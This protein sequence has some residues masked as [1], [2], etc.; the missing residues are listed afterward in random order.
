MLGEEVKLYYYM[1]LD[2]IFEKLAELEGCLRMPF[3]L[4]LAASLE[5]T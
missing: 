4:E 3:V 1:V 5:P 2:T